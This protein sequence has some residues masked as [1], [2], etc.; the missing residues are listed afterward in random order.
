MHFTSNPFTPVR[1]P[2][3]RPRQAS[4]HSIQCRPH[5]SQWWMRVWS[6]AQNPP[7]SVH[8]SAKLQSLRKVRKSRID[9]LEA[10]PSANLRSQLSSK[11]HASSK[12]LSSW[13]KRK[14]L[15]LSITER[16]NHLK[17]LTWKTP[18]QS[19]RS[20]FKLAN[21]VHPKPW[22]WKK[23]LAINTTLSKVRRWDMVAIK[24][25]LRALPLSIVVARVVRKLKNELRLAKGRVRLMDCKHSMWKSFWLILVLNSFSPKWS[26]QA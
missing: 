11:T 18:W 12:R 3:S 23:R 13:P 8:S 7:Y 22:P 4:T 20:R 5:S 14:V 19:L 6:D 10:T 2:S 17:V 24:P 1:D 15:W 9:M 16:S 25:R 26:Q 21:P